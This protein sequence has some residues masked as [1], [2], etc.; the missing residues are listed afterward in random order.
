MKRLFLI[1][2]SWLAITTSAEVYTPQTV[3][4]PRKTD[5]KAFVANPD[6]ILSSEE[7]E[8]IQSVAEQL[9]QLTGVE[10]V[11]VALDD[12][13]D[14]FAFDFTVELF[15]LWGIGDKKTNTGLLIFFT[16]QQ[17]D[18]RITTGT[19]LEGLLT[20]ATSYDIILNDII[21]LLRQGQYGNGLLAGNQA[22]YKH[23]TSQRALEE[24]L[25][26]YQP[27]EPKEQPWKGLGIFAFFIAMIAG[28]AYWA[29]PRCPQCKKK[30]A[31]TKD[32]ILVYATYTATGRGIHHHT[33]V[34]CGHKWDE[35]YTIAKRT[36]STSS[37]GRGGGYSSGGSSGG[38][39]GGGS[40]SGGGA[41][42]K[43]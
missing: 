9:Y 33:C 37:S 22:V 35:P 39:Y 8:A 34:S 18:I 28:L 29:A 4:F 41:G 21:P 43:W 10:M 16:M 3:P 23:L 5:A 31:R 7:Q 1:V 32:E 14:A 6:N 15:N 24:L 25:F 38:S 17:H 36:R 42:S 13:G 26:G 19:G 20:D 27:K 12:I 30:G 11:T 2:L 40:T